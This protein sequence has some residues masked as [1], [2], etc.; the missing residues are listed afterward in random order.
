MVIVMQS[1]RHVEV[2]G[3]ECEN[4]EVFYTIPVTVSLFNARYPSYISHREV[5][6][7]SAMT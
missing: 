7:L 4:R 3:I 1:Y 5:S 6:A 2:A